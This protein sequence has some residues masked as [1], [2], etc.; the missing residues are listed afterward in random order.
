MRKGI[1]QNVTCL[2]KKGSTFHMSD[3]ML[4]LEEGRVQSSCF[5]HSRFPQTTF[6]VLTLTRFLCVFWTESKQGIKSILYFNNILNI[7][8]TFRIFFLTLLW[9]I[10]CVTWTV[11]ERR[12]DDI[13]HNS[14]VSIFSISLKQTCHKQVKSYIHREGNSLKTLKKKNAYSHQCQ[15]S[16]V[17]SFSCVLLKSEA[18]VRW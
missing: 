8:E 12:M 14:Q 18:T 2:F 7:L 11:T 1:I 13:L 16:D 17:S 3:M 4:L 15:K 6:F 10:S 5:T 9:K